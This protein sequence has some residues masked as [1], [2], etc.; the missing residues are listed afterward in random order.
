M[1]VKVT[2]TVEV[3]ADTQSAAASEVEARL[4]SGYQGAND[5]Y[6][7]AVKSIQ[8]AKPAYGKA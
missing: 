8:T 1:R 7:L 5:P 6:A 3:D 2:V 4:R